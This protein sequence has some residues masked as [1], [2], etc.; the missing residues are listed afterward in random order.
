[1]GK[2]RKVV[3]AHLENISGDVLESYQ[4]QI[5][6]LIKG[7]SGIYALY[8]HNNLY[9]VGLATNLMGRLKRHLRDHHRRKWNRFSV[10]VTVHNDH[11]KELESLLL[12]MVNPRG[13]K[14]S[15]KFMQSKSLWPELNS[16]IKADDEDRRARLLG[17]KL[18]K[19]RVKSKASQAKGGSSLAGVFD[20][21]IRLKGLRAGYEYRASLRRDGTISYDGVIYP[22]P[23]AAGKAATGKSTNGWTFWRYRNKNGEWVRLKTLKK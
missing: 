1:M 18:A 21:A 7:K 12:R 23:S 13:N 6:Q 14:Q 4:A 17:D 15:G 11:M 22:S 2:K 8:R 20:R 10:Y 16:L 9:Y 3:V 19:R 5:R